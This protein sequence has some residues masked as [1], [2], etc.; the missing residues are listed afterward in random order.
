MA[1]LAGNEGDHAIDFKA[2]GDKRSPGLLQPISASV[3]TQLLYAVRVARPEYMKAI[4]FLAKRINIDRWDDK[5]D[6]RLHKLMCNVARSSEDQLVGWIGDEPQELSVHLF[7]DADFAGCPYTLRS[8]S[9]YR[10][11]VQGPNSRFP[12]SSGSNQQTATAQFT[13][14]AELASADFA[15]RTKGEPALSLLR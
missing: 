7:C 1:K 2:V 8:T 13:P 11:D 6:E 12:M 9:G 14:E 5:C 4:G 3:L 15:M 10:L